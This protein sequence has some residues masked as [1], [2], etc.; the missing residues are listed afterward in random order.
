MSVGHVFRTAAY[1]EQTNSN[2]MTPAQRR[3][4]RHKL[5]RAMGERPSK[6]VKP[7][8]SDN[9]PRSGSWHMDRALVRGCMHCWEGD[10]RGHYHC[11]EDAPCQDCSDGSLTAAENIAAG[12]GPHGEDTGDGDASDAMYYADGSPNHASHGWDVPIEY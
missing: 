8:P 3:R 7:A 9:K 1:R 11:R 2:E 4:A 10:T 12:Y 5:G 6:P